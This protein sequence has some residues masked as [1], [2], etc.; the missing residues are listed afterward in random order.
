MKVRI[1]FNLAGHRGEEGDGQQEKDEENYKLNKAKGH[2][3]LTTDDRF[4]EWSNM[5]SLMLHVRL[6]MR[7]KQLIYD[8][9]QDKTKEFIWNRIGK[10][11]IQRRS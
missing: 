10:L 3:I 5:V 9:S 2:S 4:H 1:T 6:Y 11:K 8:R 7:S